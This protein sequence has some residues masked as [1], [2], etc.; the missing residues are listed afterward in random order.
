MPQNKIEHV[1]IR[2]FFQF[3]KKKT[4]FFPFRNKFKLATGKKVVVVVVNIV[5]HKTRDEKEK[6]NE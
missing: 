3:K 5:I 2:I 1:K 6:K 4:R